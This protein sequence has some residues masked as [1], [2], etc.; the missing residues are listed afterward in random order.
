MKVQVDVWKEIHVLGNENSM[1]GDPESRRT[2][3]Y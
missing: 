3:V 2:V 1:R